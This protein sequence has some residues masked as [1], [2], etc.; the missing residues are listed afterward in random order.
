MVFP[1]HYP[2][3]NQ[4][5]FKKWFRETQECAKCEVRRPKADFKRPGQGKKDFT[6]PVCC[7]CH[8]TRNANGDLVPYRM[9]TPIDEYCIRCLQ[10]KVNMAKRAPSEARKFTW[11]N[12]CK[13]KKW[14]AWH[15]GR[16]VKRP[17]NFHTR[18][19][20]FTVY[21]TKYD[22]TIQDYDLLFEY[23]NRVCC[24]C[25]KMPKH[26]RLHID[27]CHATGDV[28]GLLCM[29]CNHGI[30]KLGDTA[31]GVQ[32]ALNYLL[33]YVPARPYRPKIVSFEM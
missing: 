8:R 2:I 11:C 1:A 10:N 19:D 30:G 21:V 25:R 14:Q 29:K 6:F 17:K 15:A 22:I 31:D 4:H 9:P 18:F 20:K 13:W 5:I 16:P 7:W 26:G 28:R 32:R 24:I 3:N 27:H 12:G 33:G 23:Q